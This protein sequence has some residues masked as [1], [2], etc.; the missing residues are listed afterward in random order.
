MENAVPHNS[1][2]GVCYCGVKAMMRRTAD[3]TM[4]CASRTEAGDRPCRDSG[5]NPVAGSQ[6]SRTS[7]LGPP[8]RE[9]RTG[10]H[11]PRVCVFIGTAFE[12]AV[13]KT[14]MRGGQ[15]VRE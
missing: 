15:P 11:E 13:T 14:I 7:A 1:D 10:V 6:L 12:D 8:H 9:T 3:G 5:G 2:Y 4:Y